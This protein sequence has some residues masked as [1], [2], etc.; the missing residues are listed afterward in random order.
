MLADQ[1][2]D[3]FDFFWVTECVEVILC[4]LI[5]AVDIVELDNIFYLVITCFHF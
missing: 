2:V 4:V 1:V 3:A 5:D